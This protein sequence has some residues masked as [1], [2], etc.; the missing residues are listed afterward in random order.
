MLRSLFASCR[1]L[2]ATIPLLFACSGSPGEPP[3][4]PA[5]G[6]AEQPAAIPEAAANDDD[7]ANFASPPVSDPA[8]IAGPKASGDPELDARIKEKHG[9]SCRF[10]RACGDDLLG[11]DCNAAADGPYY[12]VRRDDLEIIAKCGGHCMTGTCTDCPPKEWTCSADYY[13]E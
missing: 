13:E 1:L 9:A 12:Y 3:A 7:G 5:K 11:I 10:A 6:S 8:P 4:E 2:P